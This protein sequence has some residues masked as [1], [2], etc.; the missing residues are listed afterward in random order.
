MFFLCI[1]HFL[2]KGPSGWWSKSCFATELSSRPRLRFPQGVQQ[3]RTC[4]M[5]KN[6]SKPTRHKDC[7]ARFFRSAILPSST[8]CF[9]ARLLLLPF[10]RL[11]CPPQLLGRAGSG[12]AIAFHNLAEL[13]GV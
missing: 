4:L 11:R 2:S 5:P 8:F 12:P 3:P 7:A 10:S 6:I 13:G 9:S 1:R